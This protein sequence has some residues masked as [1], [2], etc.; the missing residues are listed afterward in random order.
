MS[1]VTPVRPANAA[2]CESWRRECSFA[3]HTWLR[4]A[5][6]V[7]ASAIAGWVLVAVGRWRVGRGQ[8]GLYLHRFSY[9]YLFALTFAL[10]RFAFSR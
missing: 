2:S 9:G 7:I 5:N 6:L 8:G 10:V 1:P 3:H 4:L